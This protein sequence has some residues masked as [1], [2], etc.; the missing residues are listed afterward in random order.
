[1]VIPHRSVPRRP[2]GENRIPG[3]RCHWS[4]RLSLK[5][6]NILSIRGTNKKQP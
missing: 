2:R 1:M 5:E 6:L 4:K 3:G